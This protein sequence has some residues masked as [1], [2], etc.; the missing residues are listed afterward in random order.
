MQWMWRVSRGFRYI[1]YSFPEPPWLQAVAAQIQGR[2]QSK[3]CSTS[4]SR[5]FLQHELNNIIVPP[6]DCNRERCLEL[7]VY[8]FMFLFVLILFNLGGRESTHSS[9][10]VL[11][12][13]YDV[14]GN[15][16]LYSSLPVLP[17]IR[18]HLSSGFLAWHEIIEEVRRCKGANL[19]H[20]SLDDVPRLLDGC[21][22]IIGNAEL[23][24]TGKS[25][26]SRCLSLK[27]ERKTYGFRAIEYDTP[28]VAINKTF[29]AREGRLIAAAVSYLGNC[30]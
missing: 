1:S 2:P 16:V 29:L 30:V 22:L 23:K 10:C 3:L 27:K 9:G 17:P 21:D 25:I 28:L 14:K 20:V 15:M 4:Y 8:N 19:N 12:I 26:R 7:Y 24:Y 18:F 11:W 13:V 6:L 5:R